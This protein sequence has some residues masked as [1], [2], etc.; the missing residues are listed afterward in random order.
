MLG[1]M[2]NDFN[3]ETSASW[4][5]GAEGVRIDQA[6]AGAGAER[7]GLESNDVW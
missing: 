3:E 7:A 4:A 5:S 6:V 2:L 1:I